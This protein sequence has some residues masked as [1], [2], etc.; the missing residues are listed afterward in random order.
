MLQINDHV[1]RPQYSLWM[2]LL[3]VS[4]DLEFASDRIYKRLD[5]LDGLDHDGPAPGRHDP[6]HPDHPDACKFYRLQIQDRRKRIV[7]SSR[8]YTVGEIRGH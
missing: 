5:G 1:F 6:D 3:F 8:D 7:I 4:Y 2:K